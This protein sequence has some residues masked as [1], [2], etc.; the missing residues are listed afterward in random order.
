MLGL[1]EVEYSSFP[2]AGV[3]TYELTS[4][5]LTTLPIQNPT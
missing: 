4:T 1:Y 5:H 3:F 2:D